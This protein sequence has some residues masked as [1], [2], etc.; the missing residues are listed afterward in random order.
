MEWAED[1]LTVA[2]F[3]LDDLEDGNVSITLGALGEMSIA[4][5][6]ASL[7]IATGAATVSGTDQISVMAEDMPDSFALIEID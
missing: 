1:F 5:C 6:A 7:M 2:S 3:V 4:A